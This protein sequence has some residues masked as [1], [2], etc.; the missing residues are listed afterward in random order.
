MS[1]NL[2]TEILIFKKATHGEIKLAD[3]L[4]AANM[5]CF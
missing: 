5:E 2:N 1:K 4:T 3:S